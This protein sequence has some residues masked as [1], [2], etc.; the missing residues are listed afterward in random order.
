MSNIPHRKKDFSR[1]VKSEDLP[2]LT[3]ADHK[4]LDKIAARQAP[5]I[6][7]AK[8]R[9]LS[10]ERYSVTLEPDVF[11]WVQKLGRVGLNS[12]LREAMKHS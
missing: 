10:R 9:S 3:E 8:K 2:P 11:A 1:Y 12:L 5:W 4:A 7:D 6:R